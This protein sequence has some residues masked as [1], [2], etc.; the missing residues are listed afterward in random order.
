MGHPGRSAGSR[1]FSVASVDCVG[2]ARLHENASA[3]Y[4]L[5]NRERA[6]GASTASPGSAEAQQGCSKRA[7]SIPAVAEASTDVDA[8]VRLKLALDGRGGGDAA[9]RLVRSPLS[10][11]GTNSAGMLAAIGGGAIR[12]ASVTR[13]TRR[14]RRMGQWMARHTR[15]DISRSTSAVCFGNEPR[16]ARLGVGERAFGESNGG[17]RARR[18]RSRRRS[19]RATDVTTVAG[20]STC[21]E[22]HGRRTLVIDGGSVRWHRPRARLGVGAA[23]CSGRRYLRFLVP[24]TV[25]SYRLGPC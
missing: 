13:R 8:H 25:C 24:L 22:T 19:A 3:R 18:R 16:R 23:R 20:A 11:G 21:G 14:W 2:E 5:V 1:F 17:A 10:R 15:H 12:D 6:F 9:R 4:A 7:T